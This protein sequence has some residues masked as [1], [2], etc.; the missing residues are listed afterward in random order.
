MIAET[1]QKSLSGANAIDGL[2]KIAIARLREHEPPE[3]YYLAFS[4]GKDSIVCYDLAVRSGVRFDAHY[5]QTTVDPPEV[6]HFI[7]EY[8]PDINW[9]KPKNSM[10]RLIVKKKMLPTRIIRYCCRELKELHGVGRTLIIGVRQAESINR[11]DRAVFEPSRLRS[12]TFF[13][14]PIVDWT[15]ENVWDYIRARNMPYCSLYDEG[16]TRIGCIMCPMQ[17]SKGM[18][19]DAERYPKYYKAYLRAIEKMLDALHAEGKD[20]GHGST[21]EEIMH[22]WIYNSDMDTET[23]QTEISN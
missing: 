10:F 8:Y 5:H 12:D 15:T 22:W 7:K 17:G 11:R 23:A 1:I 16:K 3:G 14:S 19:R 2:A 18:L 20:N 13:L 6:Q 4:G 9:D 21:P